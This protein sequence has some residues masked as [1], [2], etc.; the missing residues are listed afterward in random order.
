MT[1]QSR[2]YLS[3]SRQMLKCGLKSH[4]TAC[5]CRQQPDMPRHPVALVEVVPVEQT[6]WGKGWRLHRPVMCRLTAIDQMALMEDVA[7]AITAFLG[8]Q[9]DAGTRLESIW[10]HLTQE[11]P[12]A[13][14]PELPTKVKDAAWESILGDD[15]AFALF[16]VDTVAGVTASKAT[17][18][19]GARP[20][21]RS[22]LLSPCACRMC[23]WC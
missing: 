20:S 22:A 19:D 4:R 23:S 1:V 16:C 8:L 10:Q 21:G 17:F 7:R 13:G 2:M 3:T 15:D 18:V 12:F 14:L 11:G 9:G 5:C 6:G